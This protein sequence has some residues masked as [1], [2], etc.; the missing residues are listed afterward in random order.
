MFVNYL[1]IAIVIMGAIIIGGLAYLYAEKKGHNKNQWFLK[2][3]AIGL[4][5]LAITAAVLK[6]FKKI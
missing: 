2:G 1:V 5:L 6:K 3:T 4:V